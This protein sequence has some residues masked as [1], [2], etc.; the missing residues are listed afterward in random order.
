MTPSKGELGMAGAPANDCYYV[1]TFDE[2][3]LFKLTQSLTASL[4]SPWLKGK[5]TDSANAEVL[6]VGLF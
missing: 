1:S 3:I 2:E 4:P 6:K 5:A